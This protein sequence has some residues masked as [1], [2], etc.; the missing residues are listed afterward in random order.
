M[1]KQIML[2]NALSRSKQVFEPQDKSCV[3][4]YVCGPT[5]YGPAHIGNARPAVV[6][7]VL[8]RLLRAVYPQVKYVRNIT[9]IDDKIN[10]QAAKEGVDIG[11]ITAR[12]HAQY[13]QN[14]AALGVLPPENEPHATQHIAEIIAMIAR[15]IESGHAYE[16]EN[17]VLF[18]ITSDSD[19][20]SLSRRSLA[21]MQAGARVEV[22]PFKRDG[23]DFVLWKP[24]PPD[25]PGW[26][27]PFGDNNGRGR[28]GWH[29]ECSAMIKKHLGETIDI[30]G[31]G[32]DL[33]FPHHENEAAQSRCAHGRPLARFWMHNG[34]LNMA[35]EKMS[36][37]QGN[38]TLIEDVLADW[39]GEVVRLALLMTHYRQMMDFT[40]D[41]LAQCHR[42]L[43]RLYKSLYQKAADIVGDEAV[44]PLPKFLAAL[45]D[46]LNT[47]QALTELMAAAKDIKTAQQKGEIIAAAKLLGIL[48]HPEKWF[49]APSNMPDDI[50]EAAIED[51]I[52]KR[53]VAR[54]A[55]DYVAADAARDQLAA[56]GVEIE[57]T[58][59]GTIWHFAT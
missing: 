36:K 44:A 6:F 55:K 41:L 35:G 17:H 42:I 40:P 13:L 52:A 53:D 22:A 8:V 58:P 30:H 28:P 51:L 37:S 49:A 20:G 59:A 15:L 45:G 1:N 7:D 48:Q 3:S 56:M 38:I 10:A 46:D 18:D 39:S 23:G 25:L 24:S 14:I 31:G 11:T 50:D 27:S 9:D 2:Y 43:D 19:Y 4:I 21:D 5:V 34:M 26:N 47:P 29:I 54:A 12:Y 16:A 32:I 33:Q 57:D